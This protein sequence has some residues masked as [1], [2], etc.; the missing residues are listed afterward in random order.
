[1]VDNYL[2]LKAV[3]Q[4][5]LEGYAVANMVLVG[6]FTRKEEMLLMPNENCKAAQCQVKHCSNAELLLGLT[7][8]HCNFPLVFKNTFL[9]H[10]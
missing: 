6:Q 8:K 4:Q 9:F 3:V 2:G 5:Y 1:M 7:F 10:C